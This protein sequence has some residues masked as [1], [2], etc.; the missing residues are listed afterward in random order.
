MKAVYGDGCT[1]VKKVCKWLRHA[2]SC[3]AGEM[4]VSDE[5]R[6][7]RPISVTR[8][9]NQC[10]VDAMIQE[11]HP[12]KQT[13]IALKL[14]IS[15]KRVHHITETLNY[16]KICARWVLKQLTYPMKVYRKAAAQEPLKQHRLKGDNFLKNIATGDES[17]VHHYDLEN[18]QSMEYRHP[19]P[20]SVKIF[21]IVPSGKKVTLSIFWDARGM[22]YTEFLTKGSTVNSDRDCEPYEHSS[23]ASTESG[24]TETCF[25]CI[26][27]M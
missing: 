8:D 1:D 11:N 12:I 2:K 18:R 22:L 6:S 13:D 15:Q 21:K 20:P 27:I 4:S 23:N 17:W 24:W 14:S 16:R 10:R 7:G 19:G 9:E 5:H 25:F 26:T 3:C